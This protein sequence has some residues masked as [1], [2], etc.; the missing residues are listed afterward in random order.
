MKSLMNNLIN[1]FPVT[2]GDTIK[3]ISEDAMKIRQVIGTCF[4]IGEDYYLTAAH[5]ISSL[6]GFDWVGIGFP[7]DNIWQ[8]SP[9]INY[10]MLDDIDVGIVHAEVPNKSL[11][12]WSHQKHFMWENVRT[13]GFPYAIDYVNLQINLRGFAGHIVSEVIF[14][15]LK[16]RPHIYELSFQAPRGLSGAP[17]LSTRNEIIGL[18]IQNKSTEM[19]ISIDRETLADGNKEIIVEKIEAL[20]LGIAIVSTEILNL[21]FQILGSTLREHLVKNYLLPS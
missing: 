15:G 10:E 9:I 21:T 12:K 2:A 17:L 13:V 3:G 19:T 11:L 6:K 8:G 1:V 5:V 4:S 20:Q 7:L 16:S 18:I 14:D